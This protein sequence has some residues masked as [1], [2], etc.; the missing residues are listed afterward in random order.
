MLSNSAAVI[1]N[2]NTPAAELG[3]S[4]VRWWNATTV[5]GEC[6]QKH[7]PIDPRLWLFPV[8]GGKVTALTAQRGNTSRDLG[9]VNAY[10]LT[11][12]VYLQALGPC[13]VEFI[14]TQSAD[15]SAHQVNIPGVHYATDINRLQKAIEARRTDAALGDPGHGGRDLGARLLLA[16]QPRCQ[17]TDQ[18][19]APYPSVN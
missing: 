11:S 3:C 5:L 12:G 13:G 1:K 6:T 16:G 4:P 9:D 8:N 18:S 10:K 19:R 2:I 17:Y 14:A 15:G 7:G